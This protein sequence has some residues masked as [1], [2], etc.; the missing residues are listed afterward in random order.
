MVSVVSDVKILIP[1]F[2][3]DTQNIYKFIY[4]LA[5]DEENMSYFIEELFGWIDFHLSKI[6]VGAQ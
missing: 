3:S 1:M 6:F 2:H 5:E 4:L